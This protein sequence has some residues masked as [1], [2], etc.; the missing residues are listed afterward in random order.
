MMAGAALPLLLTVTYFVAKGAWSDL[1]DALFVFAPHYTALSFRIERFG[2]LLLHAVRGCVFAFSAVIP[3]GLVLLAV[4]PVLGSSER[5]GTLHVAGVIAAA[6]VG[7]AIQAKFFPYHYDA[8]LA[9][10]AV[11]AGWGLW[12]LWVRLRHRPLGVA[13]IIV[14]VGALV[15]ARTATRDLR[16][17]FR[18]RCQMRLAALLDPSARDRIDARLYSVQEVNSAAN[19]EVA[20]WV[21]AHTQPQDHL[22]IWGFEP[23]IY[24][25]AARPPSTRYIYDVP[26][27][28]SWSRRHARTEL[29]ADL[30]RRPPAVVLIEHHDRFFWVTG[31]ARGSASALDDFPALEGLLRDAYH[32]EGG[33]E[34]FDIYVRNQGWEECR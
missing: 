23:V 30:E 18:A 28:V 25:E 29:L 12:K 10:T 22:Y 15:Y 3:V 26:Q 9:L 1:H 24:L 34:R 17:S 11:L 20:A 4:L 6:L 33:I 21:D 16:D 14:L 2:P 13:A 5:E 27:R 32:R 19:R 31:D 8:A 7:V